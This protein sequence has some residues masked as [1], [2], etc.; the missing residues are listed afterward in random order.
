M[1]LHSFGAAA[2]ADAY[3]ISSVAQL[4]VA[5]VDAARANATST[6]IPRTLPVEVLFVTARPLLWG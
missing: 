6:H 2:V 4:L 1:N 3:V 5:R